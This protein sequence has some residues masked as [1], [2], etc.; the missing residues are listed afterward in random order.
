[1]PTLTEICE[2][3]DTEKNEK[4][5]RTFAE[6]YLEEPAPQGELPG[7]QKIYATL[8]CPEPTFC[9]FRGIPLIDDADF[10]EVGG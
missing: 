2:T 3:E 6:I 8:P 9:Y 4:G 7:E 5:Y 1:M 10:F